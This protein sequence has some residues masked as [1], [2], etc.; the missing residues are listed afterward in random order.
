MLDN[1]VSVR[2]MLDALS[3][4]ETMRKT[5][6]RFVQVLAVVVGLGLGL[7]W[8]GLWTLV[9]TLEPWAALALTA[10]Q[11]VMLVAFI[12]IVQVIYARGEDIHNLPESDFTMMSI[13]ATLVRLPGEV[14]FVF[15]ALFSVPAMLLTWTGAAHIVAMFGLPI[16]GAHALLSG[17]L[18]FITCWVTGFFAWI[19]FS[20][21][22]EVVTALFSIAHD[23]RCT[24]R[25]LEGDSPVQPHQQT[26]LPPR[27]HS[28]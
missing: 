20:L 23:L 5:M 1:F 2:P 22:A 14:A 3:Q 13:F 24:R 11:I 16:F 18:A 8:I 12:K 26:E 25:S 28:A 10:T 15:F 19:A 17:V 7:S 6:G 4:S 21:L 27:A 9:G